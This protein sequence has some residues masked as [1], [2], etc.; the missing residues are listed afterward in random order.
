MFVRVYIDHKEY[1]AIIKKEK[2]INVTVIKNI[3]SKRETYI[4]KSNI[5]VH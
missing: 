4:R 3:F 5:D 1:A 2:T